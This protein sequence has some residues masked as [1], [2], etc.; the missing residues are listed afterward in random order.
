MFYINVIIPRRK[1][2]P[3]KSRGLT[4]KAKIA[5]FIKTNSMTQWMEMIT[6]E[7]GGL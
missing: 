7:I 3:T 4:S 2:A 1:N 5:I 6:M